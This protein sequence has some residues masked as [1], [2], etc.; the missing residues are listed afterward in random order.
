MYYRLCK[1]IVRSQ[2]A[3]YPWSSAWQFWRL[4]LHSHSSCCCQQETSCPDEYRPIA[5]S[6]TEGT[7]GMCGMYHISLY[8]YYDYAMSLTTLSVQLHAYATNCIVN[9]FMQTL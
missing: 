3:G 5:V 8:L 7:H 6:F 9:V 4:A 1:N 2:L